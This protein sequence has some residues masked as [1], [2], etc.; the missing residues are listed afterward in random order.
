MHSEALVQALI[1][2]STIVSA[3][4]LVIHWYVDF[5][6]FQYFKQVLLVSNKICDLVRSGLLFTAMN[7]LA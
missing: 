2:P 4:N 1:F 7:G 3:H 6:R 5:E